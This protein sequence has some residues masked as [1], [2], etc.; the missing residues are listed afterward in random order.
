MSA[1]RHTVQ[2]IGI[3]KINGARGTCIFYY[4]E[5]DDLASALLFLR[6]SSLSLR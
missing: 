2:W 1:S 4:L 5:T 6:P 3:G